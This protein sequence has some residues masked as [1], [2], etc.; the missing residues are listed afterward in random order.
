MKYKHAQTLYLLIL[1]SCFLAMPTQAETLGGQWNLYINGVVMPA[2]CTS[3]VTE[4]TQSLGEWRSQN[5][6]TVGQTTEP[7]NIHVH[8]TGCD[9][10]I[11]G[12]TVTVTGMS[13]A[14]DASLLVLNNSGK[15]GVATGVAIQLTDSSG[16]S[17]SINNSTLS[18]PL[19]PG[20]NDI[21]FH[22]AYKV[23]QVPVHGGDA[24]AVMYMDFVYQ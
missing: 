9:A 18:V 4:M 7:S 21:L 23:T 10:S 16:E 6:K 14:N 19:T 11:T 1:T 17:I 12:T 22:A 20:D 13:D 2:S 8:L 5:L 24:N 15:D 3:E